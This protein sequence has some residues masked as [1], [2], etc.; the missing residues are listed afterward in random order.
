MQQYGGNYGKPTSPFSVSTTRLTIAEWLQSRNIRVMTSYTVS[1]GRQ[2]SSLYVA[3][4]SCVWK[5]SGAATRAA[6]SRTPLLLTQWRHR[7][8]QPIRIQ[9]AL[10][11]AQLLTSLVLRPRICSFSRVALLAEVV[12]VSFGQPTKAAEIGV[13]AGHPKI[14]V[15]VKVG[16]KRNLSYFHHNH[17][18]HAA[19][20]ARVTAATS[21]SLHTHNLLLLP[22]ALKV[23]VTLFPWMRQTPAKPRSSLSLM[24]KDNRTATVL[25]LRNCR[26]FENS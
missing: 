24:L 4:Y 14:K 15:R 12:T 20:T 2:L 23:K 6:G 8:L 26:N 13:T 18:V 3:S 9:L 19:A 1:P 17:H 7:H 21:G 5:Q 16:Q 11:L 10:R 25:L 22:R